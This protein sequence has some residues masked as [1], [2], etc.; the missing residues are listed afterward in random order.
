MVT[1]KNCPKHN[2]GAGEILPASNFYV[3]KNRQGKDVLA[4]YCKECSKTIAIAYHQK[5]KDKA[6]AAVRASRLRHPE[7]DKRHN[8]YRKEWI[9]ADRANNPKKHA[10]RHWKHSIKKKYGVTPEWFEQK[11]EEQ[12]GHCAL[13]DL[14]ADNS[15]RMGVDHNHETQQVRGV[16]CTRCNNCLDRIEM[17][18]DWPVRAWAYLEH[19]KSLA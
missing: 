13:C 2:Q 18:P 16:L 3:V 12:G 1:E 11:I 10:F 7:T 15:R 9:T 14:T 17:D 8:P 4:G 19:Y 6:N 5:H